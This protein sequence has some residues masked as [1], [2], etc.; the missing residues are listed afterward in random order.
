MFKEKQLK[1]DK[2]LT[3]ID[4]MLNRTVENG[5]TESEA[6]EA[7][8]K[9]QYLMDKYDITLNQVSENRDDYTELIIQT[10]KY[11]RSNVHFLIVQIGKLTGTKAYYYNGLNKRHN[12]TNKIYGKRYAFFGLKKDVKIAEYLYHLLEKS[13]EYEIRKFKYSIE[14]KNSRL[15][16]KTKITSFK[17]G[18]ILRLQERL[19]ELFES[20]NNYTNEESLILYNKEE[21]VN[22]QFLKRNNKIK[23]NKSTLKTKSIISYKKGIEA[24]NN[25]NINNAIENNERHRKDFKIL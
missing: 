2:I 15:N 22:E 16:G 11:T 13:I 18:L 14:Y 5:C 23:K 9:V 6:L 20:R 12:L 25:I 17:N 19:N 10:N 4:S 21:I 1:L 3:Q 8:K 7:V 24:A